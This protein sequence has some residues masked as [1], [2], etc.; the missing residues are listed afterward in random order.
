[1]ARSEQD[2]RYDREIADLQSVGTRMRQRM[3]L[4]A[5]TTAATV[6]Q[7]AARQTC[8]GV[9]TVNAAL[10]LG[11]SVDVVVTWPVTFTDLAYRVDVVPLTG[12]LGR[13]TVTEQARSSSTITMRVTATLAVSAGAQLLLLASG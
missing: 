9:A 10:L 7:V 8:L 5:S 2:R 6:A 4:M 3:G 11:T 13:A 12:V 1:M